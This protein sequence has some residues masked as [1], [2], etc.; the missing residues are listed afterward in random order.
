MGLTLGMGILSVRPAALASD[1][2]VAA[3]CGLGVS[4]VEQILGENILS[5]KYNE[6]I[7]QEQINFFFVIVKNQE[8]FPR[9][10]VGNNEI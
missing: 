2:S 6:L 1:L 7:Q 8:R 9:I 10:L 3:P 4:T 5:T